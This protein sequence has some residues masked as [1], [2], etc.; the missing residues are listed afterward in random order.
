M[1]TY[2]FLTSIDK[3]TRN[4]FNGATEKPITTYDFSKITLHISSVQYTIQLLYN[5]SFNSLHVAELRNKSTHK[6]LIQKFTNSVLPI[7]KEHGVDGVSGLAVRSDKYN[8]YYS[9][10]K[11]GYDGRLS[12]VVAHRIN[13]SGFDVKDGDYVSDLV[14]RYGLEWW[15]TYGDNTLVYF[16][17]ET[18]IPY[19]PY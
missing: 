14:L 12:N 11:A 18:E 17:R 10:I 3:A 16:G 4:L 8:G 1:D 5:D 9:C 7:C 15:K 6:Q 19:P 2:T 13:K